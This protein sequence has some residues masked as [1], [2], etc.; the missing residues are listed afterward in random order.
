MSQRNRYDPA[1]IIAAFDAGETSGSALEARF[2]VPRSSIYGM[3][4]RAGRKCRT[5]AEANADADKQAKV[6][7]GRTK[8]WT[9]ERR[10]AFGQA[11][12]AG[13]AAAKAIP[14]KSV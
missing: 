11:M 7:A 6:A 12:R 10:A 9:P 2:G 3:L 5:R 4:R 1:P 8:Y 14:D 13:H